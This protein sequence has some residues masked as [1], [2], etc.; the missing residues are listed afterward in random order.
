M[1]LEIA[2]SE[3]LTL[4]HTGTEAMEPASDHQTQRLSSYER[5]QAQRTEVQ[6]NKTE[7]QQNLKE[8]L[9]YYLIPKSWFEKFTEGKFGPED[10]V[11]LILGKIDTSSL[12]DSSGY[13]LKS[14]EDPAYVANIALPEN[15]FN[16]L[17]EWYGL[18]DSSEPVI[19]ESVRVAGEFQIDEYP[20][21]FVLHALVPASYVNRVAQAH[22][23]PLL[24]PKNAQLK[25]IKE[26]VKRQL[27]IQTM[28]MALVTRL[29][30]VE[31]FATDIPFCLTPSIFQEIESKSLLIRNK[32]D[33][34]KTLSEIG[35]FNSH[36]IIEVRQKDHPWP[37][38]TSKELVMTD[39]LIGLSN[40]GNSCYM[41]SALQCL[42]HVPE[43][44]YYFLHDFFKDEINADNPLGNHGKVAMAFGSLVHTLYARK[45]GTQPSYIAPRDFKMT[46]GFYN[47]MFADYHQQ[48]SQEFLAY[49][50]DGLHEDL[51]RILKKP[52][53]EKP[54]L[55]DELVNNP[56]EIAKLAVKCWELH[57]LRNNS[58]IIDLFV[59]M[60]K[61]TLVC[62]EC[63]KISITFDPYND[64]TLPLPI[65]KRWS[66]KVKILL[67]TGHPK[68]LE[69]ELS[70]SATFSDLKRYIA[71]KLNIEAS[72]L[73]GCEL[74][75]GQFYK[76]YESK[77][78]DA[79]YLPISDLVSDGDDIIFYQLEH[80]E[81]DIIVPV[82]NTVVSGTH[83]RMTKP[84]GI[85][86]FITLSAEERYSYGAIR[87]KLEKRYDQ[88]SSYNYFTQVRSR[89]KPKHDIDDFPLLKKRFEKTPGE[90]FEHDN[91][92]ESESDISL[93]NPDIPGNYAFQIKTFESSREVGNTRLSGYGA[94]YSYGQS[95]NED[96]NDEDDSL[97]VPKTNANFS[98]LP[99][100]LE[101]LGSKKRQ[102]YTYHALGS[103]MSEDVDTMDD[104]D[105][106]LDEMTKTIDETLGE[107][108]SDEDID[109]TVG[110]NPG[111]NEDD[112]KSES[113]SE[114]GLASLVMDTDFTGSMH[115]DSMTSELEPEIGDGSLV[116]DKMALVCEWSPDLFDT[117]FTGIEED[118][119]GGSETW[120]KP[121]EI[122]NEEI[123]ESRR[124]LALKLSSNISLEDCLDLFSTPEVLGE[125]D[126]WFCPRC[127]DHRQATKKIEIWSVPDILTIHLKRFENQR[128]F[129]DKIDAVVDFPIEG[130]DMS[131]H[132]VNPDGQ[133]LVYDLFAVDNHYG[134]LGGGHYT[135]YIKNFVDGKWYYFDD[136]RVS[137]ADPQNSIK[138]S[139]YLLFYRKRTDHNLGGE[140]VRKV[141]E[142]VKEQRA[143]EADNKGASGE[144]NVSCESPT[145]AP[146]SSNVDSGNTSPDVSDVETELERES[147]NG[148][149]GTSIV[150]GSCGVSSPPN[151][152]FEGR[153][154][155]KRH[156][157]HRLALSSRGGG[158]H[159]DSLAS[160]GAESV[161]SPFSDDDACSIHSSAAVAPDTYGRAVDEMSEPS[162]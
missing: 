9:K 145:I 162:N 13:H 100:L 153:N 60:Y 134:G 93:A 159:K 131:K 121:E 5:L 152:V 84:F 71:R 91:V 119:E 90:G 106:P 146:L 138:G 133:E 76:N 99:G 27:S 160:E 97:W 58:I 34:T 14:P 74:F 115:P 136:S 154:R 125:H 149:S 31:G 2:P 107:A 21:V 110:A 143:K 56:E 124:K 103:D 114:V 122:P 51:N 8:G 36:I 98:D 26:R 141:L 127:K 54:E 35:L 96:S 118:G 148:D 41:N 15:I 101:K 25:D 62:P 64:L 44:T 161:G 29:W 112:A 113:S 87:E 47:S 116:V 75:N 11:S 150:S 39:G 104:D 128:R 63:G 38:A 132:V 70:K 59:G 155:R 46:I 130:L 137:P 89:S 129:S 16:K 144:G 30:L 4:N 80:K 53:V 40:L 92:S 42:V 19:R 23:K 156:Q 61:S 102:F 83:S 68:V 7:S 139:A 52:Y 57:K 69:V 157:T 12:L 151:E 55:S 50:L 49:L 17:C 3:V 79:S 45:L 1:Y 94:G 88:L 142:H 20:S 65:N 111:L 85:P 95:H 66:H 86:F 108:M 22:P 120:S 158:W 28:G 109:V 43:L 77:D 105:H 73:I 32:S 117:F 147:T 10:D 81:G 82:F 37:S 78:S 67:D 72:D 135:A 126:L 33:R 123:E 6:Q 18:D 48:D 24:I 140:S